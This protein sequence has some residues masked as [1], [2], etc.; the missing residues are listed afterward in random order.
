MLT[1]E[2]NISD[3]DFK[4]Y[5]LDS[6]KIDFSELVKR[7]DAENAKIALKNCLK[8]AKN[9]GLDKLTEE[10]INYEIKQLRDEKNHS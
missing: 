2:V 6:N 10:E 8:I 1:L 3:K 5:N 7:I 4:N 9:V